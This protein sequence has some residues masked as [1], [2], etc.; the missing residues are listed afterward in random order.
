[1]SGA[2]PTCRR[3]H[4]RRNPCEQELRQADLGEHVARRRS[5]AATSA[6]DS[7]RRPRRRRRADRRSALPNR[8]RGAQARTR[9][10]KEKRRT[11]ALRWARE[12]PGASK[13]HST[14][15]FRLIGDASGPT[16]AAVHSSC[17][18][19]A[20]PQSGRSE[21]ASNVSQAHLISRRGGRNGRPARS[22]PLRRGSALAHSRRRP[23]WSKARPSNKRNSSGADGDTAG[24]IRPGADPAGTSAALRGVVDLAGAAPPG[25]MAG[26]T[27]ASSTGPSIGRLSTGRPPIARP[28]IAPAATGPVTTGRPLI[29]PA[30]A[31]AAAKPRRGNPARRATSPIVAPYAVAR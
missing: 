2:R 7:R 30:A 27:Q 11:L 17:V 12:F 22:C 31:N 9:R 16:R 5:P 4:D 25:G 1:M 21:D 10:S 28:S 6:L 24:T 20:R 15:R 19:T 26:A 29:A 18:Q 14:P 13:A 8:A 23:R 3:Q